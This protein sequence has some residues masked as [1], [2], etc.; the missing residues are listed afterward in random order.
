M[1]K[2]QVIECIESF[3]VFEKGQ[4]YYCTREESDYFY[5]F[6]DTGKFNVQEFKLSE[7]LKKCFTLKGY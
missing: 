2:G 1:Y 5:I 4:R 3:F 6:N 7:K